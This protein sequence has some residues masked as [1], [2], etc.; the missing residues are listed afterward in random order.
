MP[1][2]SNLSIL[3]SDLKDRIPESVGNSEPIEPENINYNCEYYAYVLH[4]V[5]HHSH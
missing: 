3:I 1:T 5:Y 4:F 2:Q